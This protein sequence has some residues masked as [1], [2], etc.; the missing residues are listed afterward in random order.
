MDYFV[1][2]D[3]NVSSPSAAA[4]VYLRVGDYLAIGGGRQFCLLEIDRTDGH[5]KFWRQWY[6]FNT[7]W[8]LDR[9]GDTTVTLP[10]GWHTLAVKTVHNS[11]PSKTDF[12]C[13]LDGTLQFTAV[14]PDVE[15]VA[16][17][18][19]GLRV[20]NGTAKFD[21]VKVIDLRQ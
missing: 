1:Q 9:L 2:A 15:R 18:R 12:E 19:V 13:S 11:S 17:G 8:H 16:A 10:T 4:G 6:D 20:E 7:G 21:N 14:Q 5:L 3:V